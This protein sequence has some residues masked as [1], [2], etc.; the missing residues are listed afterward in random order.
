MRLGLD[1][2]PTVGQDELMGKLAAFISWPKPAVYVLKGY[3][4]TGK[5]TMIASIVRSSTQLKVKIVLLAPTGRAAKVISN[6]SGKNASTIHRKIYMPLKTNDGS[7]NFQRAP[8]LH[9]NTLF[10]VDEASMIGNESGLAGAGFNSSTLL[11]DLFA[12][13]FSGENCKMILVGDTA[14][15]PPIGLAISPAL[16]PEFVRNEYRIDTGKFELTDVVRQAEESGILFNATRLRNM[17][18]NK[19]EHYP[20]FKL[21]GFSD[22]FRITGMELEDILHDNWREYGEENVM[23]ICRSNKRAYQF[24]MQVR[25]RLLFRESELE[26]GDRLMIVRNNYHWMK[27]AEAGDG[28]LA[29]GEM[30]ELVKVRRKFDLHDCKFANVTI[31]LIDQPKADTLEATVILDALD[32]ESPALPQ[33]KMKRLY[34]SVSIDFS[35][36]KSKKIRHEKIMTDP[37]YNALQ[38]K[39]AY[40]VTC[41]K[42]QGG[43]WDAV[44]I[45]QGYLT[46]DM[47][48]VEFLRWLY[49]ALTR[50]KQKI[51]LVN[52]VDEFFEKEMG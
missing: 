47:I 40:A 28:F 36:E 41:H 50:A 38:I 3:A 23:V 21:E 44:F 16:D 6:Y 18:S 30:I 5:T 34:Q 35:E 7:M 9:K 10:I 20:S 33:E 2:E 17:I 14:Q 24:N 43:Q 1:Y 49:T 13:V 12:Y 52:F 15:L 37:H 11:D 42:A 29:N 51:Y 19:I 31:R 39:Y 22:I 8:N 46:E 25:N 4:G 45:D 48:D 27:I 32:S 26:T